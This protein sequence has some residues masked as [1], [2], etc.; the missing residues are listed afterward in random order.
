MVHGPADV[1]HLVSKVMKVG[2]EGASSALELF[3]VRYE[4]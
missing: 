4:F 3:R 2:V 1:I